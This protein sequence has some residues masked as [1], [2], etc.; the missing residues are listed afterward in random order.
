[1]QTRAEQAA[2]AQQARNITDAK[3]WLEQTDSTLQEMLDTARR[4]R[5]L[6]VQGL[7]T[8][9]HRPTPAQKALATEVSVA[10][11]GP[12]RPGQ[13]HRPGPARC[14]AASPPGTK[15]YDADRRLRRAGRRAPVTRRVSDTRDRPGRHHRAR[16]LRAGRRRPVRRRRADRHRPDRRPRRRSRTTSP[17]STSVMKKMMHGGRRRRRPRRPAS[18]GPSRSTPTGR[19]RLESQLGR[20]REHRPAEHDHAAADAAGRLRGRAGGDG[21]GH[22]SPTLMDYLR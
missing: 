20:D 13:H 5:D 19:S 10:A 17:T 11:R 12:A 6:T 21:Q 16:G 22:L 18:S 7:N 15:A 8:G 2:V 3:S 14:S 1:M 9:A 4:V